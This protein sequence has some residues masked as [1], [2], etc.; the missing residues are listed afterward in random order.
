[1]EHLLGITGLAFVGLITL[2]LALRH[3]AVRIVLLVAFAVRAGAALFHFYVAPLP[4]GGSD[5]RSFERVAWE[6]A[7]GGFTGVLEAFTGPSS[8]FISWI[9]A[10]VYSITDRS[11]LMAQSLSVLAGMGGIFLIWRLTYDLWGERSAK[12]AIWVAA[13]F[14]N[15]VQYS[16]L[17][18][19]EA[20]VVFFFLLGLYYVLRWT[21]TN[22]LLYFSGA[23]SMFA[24]GVFF[25][26]AMVVAILALAGLALW[27]ESKRVYKT[28]IRCRIAVIGVTIVLLLLVLSGAFIAA[29]IAVPKLGAQD[30]LMERAMARLERPG[31]DTAAYPSWTVPSSPKDYL[32]ALPAKSV[33]LLFAPFPWDIRKPSHL[34]GLFDGLLYL[35]LA[36]FLWRNR[37]AVWADPGARTILLITLP[38]ILTFAVG[39]SNFGTGLR[40]RA[41]FVSAIIVMAAPFIPRFVVGEKRLPVQPVRLSVQN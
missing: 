23:I 27:R 30:M 37:K 7:Q 39:S 31:R 36:T 18:M 24:I 29:G 11:P 14:P 1:M 21:R 13:L 26:G 3:P 25:H 28:L 38:L 22:S 16:A 32:W 33:Y 15:L 19:R 40:H 9:I 6:W 20:F 34:I 10:I 35:I 8:Y 17:T 4:D 2:Y 5:A 12:K 41:K